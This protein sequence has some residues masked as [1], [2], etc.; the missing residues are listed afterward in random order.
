MEEN[1]KLIEEKRKRSDQLEP[2]A[3]TRSKK[4]AIEEL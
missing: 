2:V 1:A 3:S 4:L